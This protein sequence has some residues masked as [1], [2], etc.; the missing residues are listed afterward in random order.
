M[1]SVEESIKAVLLQEEV[2]GEVSSELAAEISLLSI[3]KLNSKLRAA[4]EQT[5]KQTQSITDR[6]QRTTTINRKVKFEWTYTIPDD[7]AEKWCA[8]AVY[9]KFSYDVYLAWVDYLFVRYERPSLF[10]RTQVR[11]KY[12]ELTG[13]RPLNWIKIHQPSFSVTFWQ[14]V[15]GARICP[16][17]DYALEV[18]DPYEIAVQRLD[19]PLPHNPRPKIASLYK[20]SNEAFPPRWKKPSHSEKEYEEDEE[21]PSGG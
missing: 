17:R 21:L 5:V 18:D 10:Q 1:A 12:P 2:K 14:L 4:L 6:T 13:D 3:A 8:A 7:S 19:R 11:S 9:K 20:I 16:E 15:R